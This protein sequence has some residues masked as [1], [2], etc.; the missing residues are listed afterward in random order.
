MA[1]GLDHREDLEGP[2][3]AFV[4]ARRAQSAEDFETWVDGLVA[5]TLNLYDGSDTR[6]TAVVAGPLA[7]QGIVTALTRGMGVGGPDAG[8]AQAG[9]I[10]E[11]REGPED[12]LLPLGL[13]SHRYRAIGNG[14]ASPV[15]E[16]LGRRIAAYLDTEER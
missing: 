12:A 7:D 14:V 3:K 5:P 9:W 15:A 2:R 4:K 10:I 6:A 8:Q 13:D 11:G 16:W 1:G